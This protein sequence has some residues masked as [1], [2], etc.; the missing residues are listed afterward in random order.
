MQST[1][2]SRLTTR[3]LFW[4]VAI[5]V[6]MFSAVTVLTVLLERQDLYQKA[7]RD[8]QSNVTRNLAAISTGLWNFDIIALKATLQGLTQTGSIVRAEVLN[9]Q[10]QVA[11]M[12]REHKGA[13]E[14]VWEVPI[15]DPERSGQIGTLKVSESYEDIRNLFTRNL[16]TELVAELVKI[17]GLAALLFIIIYRLI[18]RHLRTLARDVADLKPGTS[19]GPIKL[20]RRKV[21]HDEL[22][23]LVS[24]INRFRRERAEAEDALQGDIAKRKLVEAALHASETQRYLIETERLAALGGL[25]AGVAHEISSP[26]GTSL[27]VASTLAHRSAD[28]TDQIASRQVRRALLVEF[29]DGCRGAAE[30]LVANLQR[31]AGLIQSFKQVAVDRSSDD[32]R[33][34]DLKLATEQVTASVR[35]RLLKS[36]SSLA[37]E[38]PSDIIMDSFPGPY[39]QVLTNLVFNAITHGFTDG[40]G[41]H[42]LIK[43]RRLG[44]DQVEITVSD[45]GGGIPVEVQRRIFDPFFTTRRAQGSTGLGLHIVYNIVTQRLGGRIT[46]T[47]TPGKGTI[48]SVT[49]PLLAPGEELEPTSTAERLTK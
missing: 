48:F 37:I 32:R 3:I 26:I 29:A 25:V 24:S 47:S 15:L 42:I 44:M 27:T 19:T 40:F 39:G 23:T 20:Q 43:A 18:T 28:F 11:V 38:I 34:F 17:G 21:R 46:L 30:Q 10:Q 8:A 13:P 33:A 41:G 6:L 4:V 31:A 16:A 45:D 2:E 36:Q 9:R 22:D 12:E 1:R 49:L 7:R 5:C 14:H 35:P